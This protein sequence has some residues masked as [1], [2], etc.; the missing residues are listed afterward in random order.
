VKVLDLFSGIGGFG[1]GLQRAG[2]STAMFCEIEPFC[3]GVLAKHWPGAPIHDDVRTLGAGTLAEH[4]LAVDLVCGG[5]PCQDISVAGKGGG[6]DGA[7][8][9]LW[10]E[11][12]RIIGEVRPR[13]VIIENVPALLHR[14]MDRVLQGLEG[15]G[16]DA[17]WRIVS[18]AD[19]G[20]PH[21]RKRLW[22]V[23]YPNGARQHEQAGAGDE[24]GLWSWLGSSGVAHP[25]QQGWGERAGPV[26]NGARRPELANSRADVANTHEPRLE[27]LFDRDAGQQP[28]AVGAGWWGVEPDVGRVAYG[29]PRRMDRLRSLGNAVVP[30]IVE[31]IGRAIMRAEGLA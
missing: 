28:A 4:G 3:R 29:V 23:A 2:M 9:G 26:E 14:G 18:A 17:E 10:F 5:F 16:Y 21:L 19:L 12:E 7:R 8:S 27:I 6:L 15:L 24:S 31:M 20:A 30:Q 1:L 11:Y 22:I 25:N 13:W